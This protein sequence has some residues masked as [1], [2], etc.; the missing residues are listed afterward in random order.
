MTPLEITQKLITLTFT[1]IDLLVT[2]IPGASTQDTP[3]TNI[4]ARV[5]NLLN[6]AQSG[7]GPGLQTVVDIAQTLFPSL[8]SPLPPV[9]PRKYLPYQRNAFF[10]GREDV[11][12]R[13]H[14][15]L[16][17]NKNAA[18]TQTIA[19]LGGI[20][21]T[22]TAIEYAYRHWGDYDAIFWCPADSEATLNIAYHDIALRLNL[23]QKDAQ[24]PADTSQAVNVWLSEHSGYLL[25]LDNADDLSIVKKYLP[26]HP[27]GH[28]LVTSRANDFA[29]LNIRGPVRL[30]ELSA[31]EALSF[32][33]QRTERE[34]PSETEITAAIDLACE[35]GYLP[36]ALEQAG[37]YIAHHEISFTDYLAAYHRLRVELLEKHGPVT[38][39]YQETIRTT[40]SK[41]FTAV[42]EKSEPAAELLTISAFFAPEAIPY[43]L[44]LGSASELGEPL[45]SQ[46]TE[47]SNTE[48]HL[49][50]LL[51]ILT[52]YS[53]IRRN[54][55]AKT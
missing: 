26:S 16:A 32:L 24:N 2:S 19:G 55:E 3:N 8:F 40:W 6:W 28:I 44:L 39:D 4:P 45:A 22:Q 9:R 36:L 43:D 31:D 54:L 48:L 7:T 49:Q 18:L 13:L 14:Q 50:E 46:L 15:A 52:E 37:A 35:L 25:L 29:V 51:S 33:M 23:P 47:A 20:G 27:E 11:L 1:N 38:G 5:A 30:H 17:Q 21:K 42:R 12:Q 10:T 34:N 41:S 53:L